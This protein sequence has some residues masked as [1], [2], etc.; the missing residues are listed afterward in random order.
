MTNAAKTNTELQCACGKVCKSKSGLT[1]HRKVCGKTTS[2][3]T[4]SPPVG[5]SDLRRILLEKQIEAVE[6]DIELK[7]K[8][9]EEKATLARQEAERKA[10]L[11]RQEA[12][13][14]AELE[15]QEAERKAQ[16]ARQEIERK[17]E[18]ERQEAERKAELARQEIERKAELEREKAER[19]S[20]LENKRLKLTE[21]EHE[22]RESISERQFVLQEMMARESLKQSWECVG[23]Y[24]NHMEERNKILT[25]ASLSPCLMTLFTPALSHS[26]MTVW[27]LPG[28]PWV[29]SRELL[30]RVNALPASRP[31]TVR[32]RDA[33]ADCVKQLT[34]HERIVDNTY[35]TV[36]DFVSVHE[37]DHVLDL[38]GDAANL[39]DDMRVGALLAEQK[40]ICEPLTSANPPPS[41]CRLP[42]AALQA[43]VGG[44]DVTKTTETRPEMRKFFLS[45]EGS[46][47]KVSDKVTGCCIY[48]GNNVDDLRNDTPFWDACLGLHARMKITSNRVHTG[49]VYTPDLLVRIMNDQ[50][51]KI[52]P[53]RMKS[54]PDR[55]KLWHRRAGMVSAFPCQVCSEPVTIDDYERGHV[56]PSQNGT[57]GSNEDHNIL[58]MCHRC[59]KSMSDS[60]AVLWKDERD[61]PTR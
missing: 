25:E 16:L 40:H 36:E 39:T 22:H 51:Q 34:H 27:G 15:R 11:A 6:T 58:I 54:M 56:V 38:V 50:I 8:D 21:R 57:F 20:V 7:R 2:G 10:E 44:D 53:H 9:S 52:R 33:L 55:L 61:H 19:E 35:G 12:E 3:L 5:T 37:F 46:I 32:V 42:S 47:L 23:V 41:A 1:Q 14:K 24:K 49:K 30:A 43:A 18:L 45:C 60:D 31:S 13:R 17:A 48:I 29:Q 4:T 28:A 26:E 59:N